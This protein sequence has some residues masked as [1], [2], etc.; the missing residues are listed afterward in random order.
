MPEAIAWRPRAAAQK[1]Q[2]RVEVT[3]LAQVVCSM[4]EAIAWRPRAASQK[5]QARVEVTELPQAGWSVPQAVAWRLAMPRGR[6]EL[7]VPPRAG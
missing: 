1:A 4:P 5:A 7:A 2:V 3:E 6:V